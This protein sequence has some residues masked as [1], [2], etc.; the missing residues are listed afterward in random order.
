MNV[1]YKQCCTKFGDPDTAITA[2]QELKEIKQ[3]NLSFLTFLDD[4]LNI[5]AKTTIDE[6][7]KILALKKAIN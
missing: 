7:G 5:A 6:E 3:R 1:F 4:F 2:Y